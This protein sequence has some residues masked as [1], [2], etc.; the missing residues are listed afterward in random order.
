MIHSH[1]IRHGMAWYVMVVV[2]LTPVWYPVAPYGTTFS[3]KMATHGVML[4][5][6][7]LHQIRCK[8]T[9]SHTNDSETP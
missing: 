4:C 6:A 1:R 8:M 5:R 2:D 3:V 7:V 9:L